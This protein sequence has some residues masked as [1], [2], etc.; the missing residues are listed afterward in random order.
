MQNQTTAIQNRQQLTQK[1]DYLQK[2]T[3]ALLNEV[4]SLGSLKTVEVEK[5][6]KLEEAV[7]NFE[8][9]LIKRALEQTRGNQ[10]R[11]A[12]LL[13]VKYS[14]FCAKVQRY[15]IQPN[16]WGNGLSL[17][18]RTPQNGNSKRAA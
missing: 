11:A 18:K 3:I 15:N 16:G 2:M 14:T 4:K 12:R 17:Q 5:G 13:N 1:I 6:I 10:K 7:S 9:Q 8:I